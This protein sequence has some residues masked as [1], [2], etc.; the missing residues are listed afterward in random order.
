MRLLGKLSALV[1]PAAAPV[2]SR[3]CATCDDRGFITVPITTVIDGRK[4][5]HGASCPPCPACR[6]DG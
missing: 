5:V 4:V 3:P 6:R 2:P 1:A